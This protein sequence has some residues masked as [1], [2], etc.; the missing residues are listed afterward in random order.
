[1]LWTA[2]CLVGQ[3]LLKGDFL[4][5]INAEI[6][7][8]SDASSSLVLVNPA[9]PLAH[10]H[11]VVDVLGAN[12][13]ITLE[14]LYDTLVEFLVTRHKEIIHMQAQHADNNLTMRWATMDRVDKI[15]HGLFQ[16]FGSKASLVSSLTRNL[17]LG[18]GICHI[19]V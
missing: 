4:E 11:D 9:D 10:K 18:F 13:K 5:L 1:M 7:V 8:Y 19:A 3:V 15:L 14:S 16:I 12:L 17:L 6:L 2:C